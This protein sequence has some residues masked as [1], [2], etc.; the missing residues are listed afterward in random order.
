MKDVNRSRKTEGNNGL[1]SNKKNQSEYHGLHGV[2][3]L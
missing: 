3:C 2:M 1:L